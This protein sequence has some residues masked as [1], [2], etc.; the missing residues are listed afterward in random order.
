MHAQRAERRRGVGLQR[1]NSKS[2]ATYQHILLCE[3][4]SGNSRGNP[5]T[6]GRDDGVVSGGSKYLHPQ[7][8]PLAR[9]ILEETLPLA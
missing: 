7:A 9:L 1:Q 2:R 8:R 4:S 6:E 5:S 3:L